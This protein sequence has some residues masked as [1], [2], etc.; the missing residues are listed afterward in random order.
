M[1][2]VIF[3]LLFFSLSFATVIEAPA[4]LVDY[5]QNPSAMEWS[6][7]DTEHFE[8]I[9]PKGIEKQAQRVSHLLETAYPLVSRSLEVYPKK[10]S[11]I[12][13]NQSTVSNGFVTLAPRR[14]EWYTTPAMDPE[15]TNTE[16]LKTLAVHEFRHVV[17]FQKTRQGFNRVLEIWLGEIGQAL[18]IGLTLPPWFLEGDAVGIETALTKGGRG[19]LP[20]LKEIYGH[21]FYQVKTT[22][23]IRPTSD[24]MTIIFP[25][26]MCTAISTQLIF[27]II[28]EIFSFRKFRKSRLIVRIIH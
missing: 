18:G 4:P 7:I 28:M 19:R 24:L 9:F 17:Q 12:L 15:L 27:E 14:S 22:I 6:K 23:M 21:Y 25:V 3:S 11:L 2:A 16:W 20:L 13:Q 1:L 5:Q 26:T 10:I 8:I